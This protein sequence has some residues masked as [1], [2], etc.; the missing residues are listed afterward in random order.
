MRRSRLAITLILATLVALGLGIVLAGLQGRVPEEDKD[1]GKAD[2]S[3]FEIGLIGDIPYNAEQQRETEVL[4]GRMDG[5]ELAFIV[6]VG[7]I[8]SGD[9]PC[10][11]EILFREKERFEN[12]AHPIVYVPG[13]NEWT[14]CHRTGYEPR[15]RLERLREIFFVGDESLGKKTIPLTRQSADYSENVR[16]TYGG[17]TFLGL[18]VPGSNNNLGRTPEADAEYAARNEANLSWLREGFDRAEEDESS[19]LMLVIQA[20][21]GFFGLLLQ[22]RTGYED[23]LAVLEEEIVAFG[24]PVVLVHGDT[25]TF[26]VD[27]PMTSSRTG[28]RVEN[29]TRVETFGSPAVHWVRATVNASDPEV[30]AFR[31][32]I[33][34]ENT[35]EVKR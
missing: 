35:D 32:E 24:K 4:F 6:H 30:F 16:W 26:R 31:P 11:D 1:E 23:L 28:E 17:V 29:F 21:P 13:D 7:D 15:E 8:K 12:S 10:T 33:V 5:E 34:A 25:H 19:A 3:K 27:K 20:N 9:S 22:E 14:D 2:V 18:N